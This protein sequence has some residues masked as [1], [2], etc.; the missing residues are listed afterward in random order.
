[1][2]SKQQ[3]KKRMAIYYLKNKERILARN[4][5][6]SN[7][8][9]DHHKRLINE[10]NRSNKARKETVAKLWEKNNPEKRKAINAK[11]CKANPQKCVAMSAK[12]R[13]RK[14]KAGG[15]FT[16]GQ[17]IDLCNK[18]GNKCLCCKRKTKLA[19]DHVVPVCK[20][21]SSCIGNIQPLCK[22]CNSKKKDKATDYRKQSE[23]PTIGRGRN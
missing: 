20:G 7:T 17:F 10:W 21:G 8:H 3:K 14:T 13:T 18:Y 9:R 15:N 6:W 22:S 19:A 1:M 11:W 23:G 4:K 12:Y 2:E 5:A 16:A